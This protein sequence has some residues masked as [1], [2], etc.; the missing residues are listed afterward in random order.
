[1]KWTVGKLVEATGGVLRQGDANHSLASLSTDTRQLQPG[2][3]FVALPGEHSD[4]HTFI[5]DALAKEAGALVIS[6]RRPDPPASAPATVAVIAV[7]DTLYALGEIARYYRLHHPIPVV[8]VTGSNG[9]TSTK[10]MVAAILGQSYEVLK[11][12]G[13]F[14]NLIGAPLTILALQPQHQAA[15]VE[16]GI[17]VVGEMARLVEITRPTV[18]LITNVQ[19]AHLE[20]LHSLDEIL[21]EKGRLWLSLQ[22]HDL[23]VVNVDDE[24]LADLSKRVRARTVTY[25]LHD[26]G[27]E[28]RLVGGVTTDEGTS[29][30]TIGLGEQSIRVSLRVL[31]LHHVANALAAA[32]VGWGMGVPSEQISLGL[33]RYQPLKMRMQMQR[34]TDGRIIIDDTYNANPGSMLA[35]VRTVTAESRGKP[36]IAVLADMREL[37][38]ESALLHRE[39][40]RQI[41]ALGGVAQLI[42]LGQMTLELAE[43]ARERGLAASAWRHAESHEQIVTWLKTEVLKDAW[44]LVKGSRSMAMERVVKG[45]LAG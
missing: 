28:V 2:D 33:A 32:A 7:L 3:C 31:G 26:A 14:N 44:I 10:E 12:K 13:N 37:G 18:G 20:G 35:A 40:G 6:D 29:S 27:A 23:A 9:K 1:M 41:A 22:P 24:R 34:L 19:P 8:G 45:I 43:G 16:M 5:A 4:G 39:V 15:V 11:N 17:N 30:F 38:V 25:S 21:R 36:V 42:T